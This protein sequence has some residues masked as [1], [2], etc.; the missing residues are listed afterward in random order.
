VSLRY[1]S[2][3]LRWPRMV[4]QPLCSGC[5]QWTFDP[6]AARALLLL[7]LTITNPGRRRSGLRLSFPLRFVRTMRPN[8]FPRS[9]S[10]LAW[11][12]LAI[13]ASLALVPVNAVLFFEVLLMTQG[14]EGPFGKYLSCYGITPKCQ[15]I[16]THCENKTGRVR[17][18]PCSMIGCRLRDVT[19]RTV[20]LLYRRRTILCC[21]FPREEPL[22]GGIELNVRHQSCQA[23]L[24]L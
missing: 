19:D 14:K 9:C 17:L 4:L 21:G 18:T 20:V 10:S 22:V 7:T 5:L 1:Y 8:N 16:F 11:H 24:T 13:T 23:F 2:F 3:A 12:L 15:C 6:A